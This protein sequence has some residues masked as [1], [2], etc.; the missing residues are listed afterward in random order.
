VWTPVRITLDTGRM[1]R[2]VEFGVSK[3]DKY[4]SRESGDT[5]EIVERPSGGLTAVLVDGQGSGPGAKALSS[6]LT[7]KVVGLIKEGVRDGVV[8]R[9]AHD[10]LFV[11]R[12]GRVSA[13]LEL[14][15]IDVKHDSVILTRNSQSPAV[16]I[17][18]GSSTRLMSNQGPIGT[19][20]FSKPDVSK[21]ALEQDLSLWIVS[22]GVAVAGRKFGSE[23][24]DLEQLCRWVSEQAGS[25]GERADRL[26]S[27]AIEADKGRPADD[28][29]VISLAITS[30]HATAIPRRMQ[31]VLPI[32]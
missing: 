31:V 25:A 10:L 19:S 4:A 24:L 30:G 3:I 14:V 11:A 23:G 22:D 26:L 5:V 7:A 2:L 18:A 32:P 9:A 6:M 20:S 21:F 29:T 28:M 12:N 15:S 8:A 17:V 16:L 13:S 1:P 27:L